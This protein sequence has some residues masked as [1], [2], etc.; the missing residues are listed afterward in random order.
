MNISVDAIVYLTMPE[1]SSPLDPTLSD[2]EQQCR[3]RNSTFELTS[4]ARGH[5]WCVQARWRNVMGIEVFVQ[6]GLRNREHA[7]AWLKQIMVQILS[8]RGLLGG[9]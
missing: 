8:D 3:Q 2:L 4:C 7:D 6:R 9:A 1:P 5:G